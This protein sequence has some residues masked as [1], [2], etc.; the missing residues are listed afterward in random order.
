[1]K[2]HNSINRTLAAVNKAFAMDMFSTE[3][4]IFIL[5]TST[6]DMNYMRET[7]IMGM[8]LPIG[9]GHVMSGK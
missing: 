8:G 7:G 2:T 9:I 4:R 6:Q 1:M 3:N 5:I